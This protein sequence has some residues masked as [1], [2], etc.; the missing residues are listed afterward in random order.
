[1][2]TGSKKW[3]QIDILF[4][5]WSIAA[6]E[7]AHARGVFP[8]SCWPDPTGV[9]AGP[10]RR[11]EPAC[12]PRCH[13]RPQF[14]ISLSVAGHVRGNLGSILDE[15][16][17]RSATGLLGAFVGAFV[18]LAVTLPLLYLAHAPAEFV[19]PAFAGAIAGAVAG[20]VFPG[21]LVYVIQAVLYFVLGF[22]G[23]LAPAWE[24]PASTPNWLLG[25]FLFGA[26]YFLALAYL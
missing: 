5:F 20:L 11:S 23:A 18:S 14:A 9:P 25:L 12:E 4:P 26:V 21:M 19:S 6:F 2:S 15:V 22:F 10:D 13:N 16:W 17:F 1:M 7:Q 24:P 8:R 3:G